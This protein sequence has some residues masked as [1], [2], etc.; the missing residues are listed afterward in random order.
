M[1]AYA[2]VQVSHD[3]IKDIKYSQ[4]FQAR[5]CISAYEHW[6]T[7]D[8]HFNL[9]NF[10]N[11]VVELLEDPEDPWVQETLKWWNMYVSF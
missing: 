8:T 9:E 6:T 3:H 11:N 10:F 2:A 4:D 5:H 1:I 7:I